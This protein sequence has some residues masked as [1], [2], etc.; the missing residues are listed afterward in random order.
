MICLW[1]Q[2]QYIFPFAVQIPG[3]VKDDIYSSFGKNDKYFNTPFSAALWYFNS[4][5]SAGLVGQN[6]IEEYNFNSKERENMLN[7]HTW[8]I[9]VNLIMVHPGN[10]MQPLQE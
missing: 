2:F 4:R 3:P 5:L 1:S 10:A 7:A 6:V 8:L 9:M